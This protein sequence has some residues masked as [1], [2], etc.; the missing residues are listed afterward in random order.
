[1]HVLHQ[2]DQRSM[3]KCLQYMTENTEKQDL[4][5]LF[6][7]YN[8]DKENQQW[9]GFSATISHKQTYLECFWQEIVN[10]KG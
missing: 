1:M 8:I 6:F 3:K 9:R 4:K 10:K 2:N 5:K 7:Q